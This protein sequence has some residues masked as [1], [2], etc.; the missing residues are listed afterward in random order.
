MNIALAIIIVIAI[1]VAI[2]SGLNAAL[3]WLLWVALIIG[4]IALIAFLIRVIGGRNTSA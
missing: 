1:I 2:F 4:A 3:H